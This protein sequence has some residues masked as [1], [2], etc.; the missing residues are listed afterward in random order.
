MEICH[1]VWDII[2][3]TS[4]IQLSSDKGDGLIFIDGAPF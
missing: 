2:S 1:T 4:A 3:E